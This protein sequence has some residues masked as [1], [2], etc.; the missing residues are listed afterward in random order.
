MDVNLLL[1]IKSSSKS[2]MFWG[3]VLII[4]N[5][6]VAINSMPIFLVCQILYFVIFVRVTEAYEGVYKFPL[7]LYVSCLFYITYKIFDYL[8][9]K[10]VILTKKVFNKT[11]KFI[12]NIYNKINNKINEI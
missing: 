2:E 9:D 1:K 6:I 10:S 12:I 7:G 4:L 8:T 3:I 11:A 5:L